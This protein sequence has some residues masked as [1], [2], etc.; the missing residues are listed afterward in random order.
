MEFDYNQLPAETQEALDNLAEMTPSEI[1]DYFDRLA[2]DHIES[3]TYSTAA[4]Y[5]CAARLLRSL[6]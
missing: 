2:T 3:G 1:C 4:D 6:R 5:I